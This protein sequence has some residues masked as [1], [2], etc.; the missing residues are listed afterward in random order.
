MLRY[1]NET[2]C[3]KL[4]YNKKTLNRWT[5]TKR[6]E[7]ETVGK[8]LKDRVLGNNEMRNR[9]SAHF[10]ITKK[11]VFLEPANRRLWKT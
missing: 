8:G 9:K 6:D 1:G 10:G 7:S 11:V 3:R 4:Y 5:E 2:L